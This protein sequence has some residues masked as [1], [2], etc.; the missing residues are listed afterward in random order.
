MN[1]EVISGGEPELFLRRINVSL[2]P[3]INETFPGWTELLSAHDI[4]RLTRRPQWVLLSM[5]LL[6]RFPRRQR[7]HGRGIGWLRADV[8][9]W[10]ARDP[11]LK[12]CRL[13]SVAHQRV[14]RQISVPLKC[15]GT[16][17]S[18]RHRVPCNAARR[19][20]G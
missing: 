13:D 11:R 4:A 12:D 16:R 19:S 8:L 5:M 14:A 9:D 2:S 1:L 10:L 6:R 15:T 18:R 7:F 3:W 20:V 17:S